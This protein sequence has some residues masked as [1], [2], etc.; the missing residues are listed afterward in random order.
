[1]IEYCVDFIC[2][3]TKKSEVTFLLSKSATL[4]L[5]TDYETLNTQSI[6][7]Q[8]RANSKIR[9]S[10]LAHKYSENVLFKRITLLI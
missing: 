9:L 3:N 10:T 2:T 6:Q 8:F 7:F 5:H 1:M 4:N